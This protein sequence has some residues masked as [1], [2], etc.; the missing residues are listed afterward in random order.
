VYGEQQ[1]LRL[2]RNITSAKI[3]I[4]RKSSLYI[5]KDY[6]EKSHNYCSTGY[7]TAELNIHL[8]FFPQKLSDMSFTSPCLIRGKRRLF[9][10]R[11]S[12]SFFH[13]SPSFRRI[14]YYNLSYPFI[15]TYLLINVSEHTGPRCRTEEDWQHVPPKRW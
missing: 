3:I 8:D 6:F 4:D 12:C 15:I 1:F 2:C 10:P 13:I 5:E 14:F 7:R 11:T 9:L